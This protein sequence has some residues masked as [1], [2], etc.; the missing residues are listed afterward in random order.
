MPSVHAGKRIVLASF[1]SCS[2]A[3]VC[4]PEKSVLLVQNAP[5]P[6]YPRPAVN[7]PLRGASFCRKCPQIKA[8]AAF[9]SPVSVCLQRRLFNA[10]FA[11]SETLILAFVSVVEVTCPL[12]NKT[13]P[14]SLAPPV[15]LAF[16]QSPHFA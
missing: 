4:G 11:F 16:F 14:C 9:L 8:F 2:K 6:N 1:R 10:I 3:V 5:P 7:Q 12:P 13:V 15:S